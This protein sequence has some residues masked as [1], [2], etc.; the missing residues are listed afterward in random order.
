MPTFIDESGDPGDGAGS[1]TYFRLCAVSVPTELVAERIRGEIRATRARL[2][3]SQTY[4]FKFS[5][6]HHLSET[7]ESFYEAVQRHE[8]RFATASIDKRRLAGEISTVGICQWLATT[9]LATI[10]RPVYVRRYEFDPAEYRPETVTADDNRDAE[11]LGTLKESFRGLGTLD[12]PRRVLIDKVRFR[13]SRADEM[14]QLADMLCG[15]VG[16][17]IDGSSASY[18]MVA[19]RDLSTWQFPS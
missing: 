9:A 13:N 7:R 5:K 12:S 17:A 15:A 10:L 3:R 1:S 16:A 19:T 6:T 4:E 2:G 18:S 8:F 11:F 14:L